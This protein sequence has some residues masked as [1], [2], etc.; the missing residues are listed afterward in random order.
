MS[1]NNTPFEKATE[2]ADKPLRKRIYRNA[3]SKANLVIDP[4]EWRANKC[5]PRARQHDDLKEVIT[6]N[7]WFDQH[8]FIRNQHGDILGKR[9]G[10][11]INH[12]KDMVSRSLKHLL[13]YSA[14]LEKFTF[15]NLNPPPMRAHRIVIK[16][17]INGGMLNAVI[18]VHY[19]NVHT[20]EITVKTAMVVDNF[21]VADNQYCLE[22]QGDSSVLYKMESRR[23]REVFSI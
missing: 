14:N 13:F 23:L 22:M 6:I 15:L 12:V 5:T 7:F 10:I 18:E 9:I 3:P 19:I 21:D 4:F 2:D 16:E 17:D 1:N 8:Y 11:D 20:Y